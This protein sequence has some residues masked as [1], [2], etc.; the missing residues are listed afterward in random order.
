LNSYSI[1][2]LLHDIYRSEALSFLQYVR[3]T[4]PYTS[5]ADKPLLER[6]REL[7]NAELKEVESLGTY[8]DKARYTVPH[9][10]AFPSVYSNYNFVNVRKLVPL[11]VDDHKRGLAKL[12][13]DA[14]GLPAGDANFVQQMIDVKRMH[15]MELEKLS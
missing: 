6:L 1:P 4:S 5:E 7:A 15:L 10:G 3:Q 8:M 11:L 14:K 2:T 12:E 9:T 13:A